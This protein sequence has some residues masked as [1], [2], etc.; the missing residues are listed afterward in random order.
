M[1]EI[2]FILEWWDYIAIVMILLVGLPHGALDAAI[3]MSIGFYD[4][5]RNKSI[6][7]ISYLFFSFLIV[8]L[9]NFYPQTLLTIF[10]FISVFHFG[11]GDSKWNNKF[12]YYLS[13]YFNGGI[14][15]FGLSYFNIYEV[16]SIYK[17]LVGHNSDKV[18]YFLEKGVWLW[19]LLCPFH[20]YINW[21]Y[22]DKTYLLIN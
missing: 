1:A 11:L 14:I 18:W 4:S 10:L 20:L 2:S 21:K 6:F 8:V 16:D 17:I 5:N 22:I 9:W 3:G 13:G 7:L 15:I 12:S 19:L